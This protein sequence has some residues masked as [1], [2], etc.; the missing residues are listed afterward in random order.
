M[1]AAER[2]NLADAPQAVFIPATF[3]FVTV[4]AI[5]VLGEA[6]RRRPV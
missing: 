5:N 6:L 2:G 1:I 3:L 4:L